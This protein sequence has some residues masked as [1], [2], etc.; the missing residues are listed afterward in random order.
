[1]YKGEAGGSPWEP[2]V[3]APEK[4]IRVTPSLIWRN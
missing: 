2:Q 4:I 3:D 1:V